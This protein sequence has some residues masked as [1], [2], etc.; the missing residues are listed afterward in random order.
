MSNRRLRILQI[1]NRYLQYGG[2]E[3]SVYRIGDALQEIHDVEYFIS[4]TADVVSENILTSWKLPLKAVHNSDVLAKLTLYQNAGRFDAWQIHNVFPIM[5]PVVYRKAI[6]WNVPI[7]HYLHNYRLSC[8]NGFFLNHGKPCQRCITGNFWPALET[9]CW[10]DSHLQSGWMG[11]IL[12]HIQ[13]TDLFEKVFQWIAISEAQKQLHVQIGLP[14][15]KIKVVHHFLEPEG[16]VLPPAKSPTALFV[17]RLSTEKGVAQLLEAWKLV[18]GGE[19]KLLIVGDGPE[20]ASLE[21]QAAGLGLKGVHFLGFVEKYKQ[22]EYWGEALFSL[23]P[24]IWMEPFG[25]TVLEA[26]AKGR[27]VIAHKIGALPELIRDGVDGLLAETG[28][29]QDLAEKMERLLSHPAQAEAMGLAGREHLE[30]QFT[31]SRWLA[32]IAKI[33]GKLK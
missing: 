18:G 21:R 9:A 2:E 27:P 22:Q 20:R 6:E 16:P 31:K 12:A 23:V 1:F 17:G 4:S 7:V 5:S 25:M 30:T 24:S 3:G 8:V 32:E 26:W 28:N 29:A 19:R 10:R 33:Y 11:M 15:D 14:E 13:Q